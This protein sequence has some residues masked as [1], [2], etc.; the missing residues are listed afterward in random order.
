MH[1]AA[2]AAKLRQKAEGWLPGAR[3]EEDGG[4]EHY[5]GGSRASAGEDAKVLETDGGDGGW[6]HGNPNVSDAA[7]LYV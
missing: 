7:E 2:G 3:G 1:E 4:G 6:V 5:M